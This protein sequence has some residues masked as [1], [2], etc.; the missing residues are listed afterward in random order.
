MS[1]LDR[2]FFQDSEEKTN[3]D[4]TKRRTNKFN[5]KYNL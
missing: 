5:T 4:V 1:M 3:K 2:N